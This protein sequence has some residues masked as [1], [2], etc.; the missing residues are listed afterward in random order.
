M[1]QLREQDYTYLKAA[2]RKMI[3]QAGGVEGAAVVTRVGRSQL[4]NYQSINHL[5]EFMPLDVIA[6]LES[7]CGVPYVTQA[8]SRLAGGYF[9]KIPSSSEHAVF[10]VH[11][12]EI[13]GEI[14]DVMKR[15]G[16]ALHDGAITREETGGLIQEIDEAINALASARGFLE[17]TQERSN[18]P[19][20][21]NVS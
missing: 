1:R 9:M 14:S 16:E 10:S 17:H 18:A 5:A 12:A 21:E 6:D 8:L 20:D 13:G 15:A 4:S 7:D 2:S 11:L 19:G 3:K